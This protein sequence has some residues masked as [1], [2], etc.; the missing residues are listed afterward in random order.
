MTAPPESSLAGLLASRASQGC[1]YLQGRQV[2]HGHQHPHWLARMAPKKRD[3][4]DGAG[5]RIRSGLAILS[6]RWL[7]LSFCTFLSDLKKLHCNRQQTHRRDTHICKVLSLSSCLV[8]CSP[9]FESSLWTCGDLRWEQ[10]LWK[11]GVA[12]RRTGSCWF[13]HHFSHAPILSFFHSI[14]RHLP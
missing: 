13:S 4:E 10:G 1:C 9:G 11:P 8:I 6:M 14:S 5:W 7:S 2:A 3:G 12:L